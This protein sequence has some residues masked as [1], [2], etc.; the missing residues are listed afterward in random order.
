[1]VPGGAVSAVTYDDHGNTLTLGSQTYLYD[2]ADRHTGIRAGTTTV[3]YVRDTVDRIMERRE[4][5]TVQKYL[6]DDGF[7]DTRSP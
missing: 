2:A 6:Y 7:G 1:V 5:S 3:D 4:G